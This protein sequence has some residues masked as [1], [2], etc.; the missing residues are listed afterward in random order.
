[1]FKDKHEGRRLKAEGRKAL[2]IIAASLFLILV[3]IS[4]QTA[5]AASTEEIMSR[6]QSTYSGIGDFTVS[7]TQ[8]SS[9]KGLGEKVFEGKLYVKK[10][11]M[12]R[13]DYLKPAKQNIFINGE[14]A[15]LY[16]PDQKQ[17]IKQD[18]SKNPDSEPALG[19]LSNIGTWQDIFT[20]KSEDPAGAGF[21]MILT[22][23]NMVTVEKVL[24]EID[25]ESYLINRLTIFENGGNKVSFNF[26]NIKT[27]SGLKDK[28]FDFKIPKGI[29]VLEY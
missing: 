12:I 10:P 5:T 25:K 7:F 17:A 11:K 27:N 3:T 6:L 29:G 15:V 18:L 2:L 23:K 28:L 21:Q 14:R 16:I 1:M 26:S 24:V 19:L 20:I 13:W 4:F 8:R 22:P 9:F